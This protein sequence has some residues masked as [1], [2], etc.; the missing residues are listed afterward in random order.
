MK[1]GNDKTKAI[2][3]FDFRDWKWLSNF[4]R[5]TSHVDDVDVLNGTKEGSITVDFSKLKHQDESGETR[6]E[7]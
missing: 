4:Q 7:V 5:F 6:F 2:V 3:T 1:V